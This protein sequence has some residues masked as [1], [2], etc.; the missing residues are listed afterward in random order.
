MGANGITDPERKMLLEQ[1]E[2]VTFRIFGLFSKDS[3]TKVGD[4]VR[5]AAKIVGEDLEMRT[6]NQIM[7]GLHLLGA[8]IPSTALL[9][10]G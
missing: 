7:G 3:R 2:R 6:Y 5:M 10:R 1:W 8:T 4:Y 9:P